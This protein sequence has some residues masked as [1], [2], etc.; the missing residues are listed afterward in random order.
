MKRILVTGASGFLGWHVCSLPVKG[1]Q[2]IGSYHENRKGIFPKTDH[3]QLN[4]T[5]KDLIWK[6]IK[7]IKPEAVF[8]LAAFSGTAFCE[9][10]PDLTFPLNVEAT[11]H[12][13]EMCADKKI[14]FLFTSSEQVFDGEKGSYAETDLPNPQNEYGKQKLEAEKRVQEIFPESAVLR[15]AVLFGN[16]S[17]VARSFLNQWLDA[18]QKMIPVTAFYDEIRPFLSGRSCAGAMY[19]LLEQGASGIFHLGG[20]ESMSR[21]DFGV[22][23]KEAFGFQTALIHKKSQKEADL[24]AFRPRDLSLDCSKIASTGL[25]LTH[26]KE[27]LDALARQMV[28]PPMA[29][30]N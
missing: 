15:I 19:H 17:E 9:K 3:Y 24:T 8:H 2:V 5:E 13:A 29:G 7:E 30:L 6:A 18:W 27:E 25:R 4:L 11:A 16:A 1:W 22:L 20:A 10:N 14:R 23:A 26:V 21:Y 28:I 12:L